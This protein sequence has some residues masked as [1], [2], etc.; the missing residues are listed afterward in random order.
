MANYAVMADTISNS[1]G[2][3]PPSF[4]FGLSTPAS[5][6]GVK[7][8]LGGSYVITNNDGVNFVTSSTSLPSNQTVTLPAAASNI[9]RQIKIKKVDTSAFSIQVVIPGGD[10]LDGFTSAYILPAQGSYI[11]VFAYAAN[12]W[13][14]MEVAKIPP[15][16]QLK[17]TAQNTSGTYTP[18]AYVT[19]IMVEMTGCGGG[20]GGGATGAAGGNG[21]AGGAAVFSVNGGA[22]IIT[23]A[24]G[25]RGGGGSLATSDPGGVV[26]IGTGSPTIIN[27]MQGQRGG[28][29]CYVPSGYFSTQGIGGSTPLGPG[30]G[31]Q[32]GGAAPG[33]AG[34]PNSGGGGAGGSTLST[35][36]NQGGAGGSSAA[37]CKF[38]MPVAKYDWTMG[39]QGTGG[40]PSASAGTGGIGAVGIIIITEYY[41]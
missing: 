40:T 17:G 25:G 39:A 27:S 3:G 9:G 11:S 32:G 19:S 15:T 5:G 20:G 41:T 35:S 33:D 34:S 6:A 13:S 7:D 26:T 29:A 38:L 24:G 14:I 1:A 36:T 12:K 18:S 37:Y 16:V 22:A 31:V 23:C 8:L 2:N 4:P 10:T 30:G 28:H 21:T